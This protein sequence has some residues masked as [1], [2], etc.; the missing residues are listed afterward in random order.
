MKF[1]SKVAGYVLG[2]RFYKGPGNK[3]THYG[4]LWSN[5]GTL[6]ASAQFT[7]ETASGWQQVIFSKPVAVS[8]NTTYVVSYRAPSGRYSVDEGFFSGSGLA[9]GPLYAFRDGE[10]GSNGVYKYGST[11]AFPTSSF[12]SSNYWVDA[13]FNTAPS[14]SATVVPLDSTSGT[15]NSSKVV[16]PAPGASAHSNWAAGSSLSCTPKAVRAG[17]SFNCSLSL[18]G[19]DGTEMSILEV[20]TDGND[21]LLPASI[22]ARAGRTTLSFQGT[23]EATAA[24]SVMSVFVGVGED[25][26]QDTITVVPSRVPVIYVPADLL[27]KSGEP[28]RFRV[29]AKDPAG[30]PLRVSADKLPPGALFQPDSGRFDW[31]PTTD[32]IGD[33]EVAFRAVNAANSYSKERLRITVGT[34]KPEIANEKSVACSANG[35]ATLTGRWLSLD[36][37]ETAASPSTTVQVNGSAARLSYVSPTRVDFQC[38]NLATGDALVIVLETKE[39]RTSAIQTTIQEA[40]PAFLVDPADDE[41]R[42]AVRFPDTLR[43]ATVRNYRDAGEPAQ[44]G[45]PIVIQVTGLGALEDIPGKLA[46]R[47]GGKETQ[48]ESVTSLPQAEGI[49]EIRATIPDLAAPGDAVSVGLDLR[50]DTGRVYRAEPARMA[51]EPGERRRPLSR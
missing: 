40:S 18:D 3:G 22:R 31:T 29:S 41:S 42:E 1:R 32:Q 47:V 51:I 34:G 7:N 25:K 4:R 38:P 9:S 26:V 16:N 50:L 11:T 28:I 2:V 45:D 15:T 8:A 20:G 35:I 14:S 17:D 21:V 5:T 13:V 37:D 48:I 6:L 49:F 39:G 10:A 23:L 46:L 43:L 24:Q 30:L 33:H 44:P 27:I 12:K 19:G 36:E